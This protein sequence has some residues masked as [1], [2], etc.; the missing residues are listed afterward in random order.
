MGL[1]SK[2]FGGNLASQKDAARI[3]GA[4]MK[5]SRRTE[6]FGPQ[7]FADNY[8]GR[9]DVL[10]LNLSLI[11]KRLRDFGENGHL[12]SQAVYDIMRD[13]FEISLREEGLSDTGVAK[14][15]KPMIRLFYDR[16][17]AYDAAIGEGQLFSVLSEKM[18]ADSDSDFIRLVSLYADDFYK[19]LKT[20]TLGDIAQAKFT[21]PA[22]AK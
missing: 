17:K 15:I 20:V 11:M 1:F 5:Q 7:R 12:L 8:D 14:R 4:V 3:Y 18:D 21:F 16:L 13:D 6:F 2:L 22:L 10:T 19:S 9:I